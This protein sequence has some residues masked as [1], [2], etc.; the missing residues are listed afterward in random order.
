MPDVRSLRAVLAHRNAPLKPTLA[1]LRRRV[2]AAL[3][4]QADYERALH[5]AERSPLADLPT[6]PD[7]APDDPLFALWLDR[8]GGLRAVGRGTDIEDEEWGGAAAKRWSDA[9]DAVH[10]EV[11]PQPD[12]ARSRL[13]AIRRRQALGRSRDHG[14]H[15]PGFA[16]ELRAVRDAD[17]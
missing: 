8:M 17:E 3:G 11:A 16:G 9:L 1:D 6:P 12:L 10:D 13:A 4:A 5:A 2:T 15:R 7:P 14:L